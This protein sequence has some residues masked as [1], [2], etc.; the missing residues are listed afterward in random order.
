MA[1]AIDYIVMLLVLNLFVGGVLVS[2]LFIWKRL[3][4]KIGGMLAGV[5]VI[6]RMWESLGL[7]GA[8]LFVVGEFAAILEVLNV[9]D[10]LVAGAFASFVMMVMIMVIGWCVRPRE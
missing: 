1:E 8:G 4:E 10:S 6:G 3:H 5:P 7:L 2:S 9:F